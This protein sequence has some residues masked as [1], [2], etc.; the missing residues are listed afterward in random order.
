MR[1][2]LGVGRFIIRLDGESGPIY[3]EYSTI[4]DA[5]IVVCASLS[6][7]REYYLSEYGTSSA[8]E[9]ERRLERVDQ[10]GTSALTDPD[11]RDT[12][13]GNRAGPN[14]KNLSYEQL[15]VAMHRMTLA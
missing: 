3:A 10:K 1:K 13:R 14:E 9:L 2:G 8:T 6:E 12:I 11:V 7:F 4:V 15:Y 5:P